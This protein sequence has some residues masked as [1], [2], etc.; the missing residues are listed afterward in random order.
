M[1]V[2]VLCAGC[3]VFRILVVGLMLDWLWRGF[4]ADLS[5]RRLGSSVVL[6]AEYES[7]SSHDRAQQLLF[8]A[9]GTYTK[10]VST[11][12]VRSLQCPKGLVE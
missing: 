5:S 2:D 9:L 11:K 4:P 6:P 12:S 1:A 7:A 8:Y 10:T 3:V